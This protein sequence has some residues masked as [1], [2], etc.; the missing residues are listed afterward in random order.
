LKNIT[1]GNQSIIKF[2][3]HA[4]TKQIDAELSVKDLWAALYEGCKKEV[5]DWL[6]KN[7]SFRV[8]RPPT[9]GVEECFN[10]ILAAGQE[11]EQELENEALIQGKLEIKKKVNALRKG[12]DDET[13]SYPIPNV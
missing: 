11:V 2:V 6:V 1:Q 4:R 5:R 10:E 13:V 9:G 12:K 7:T 8:R 3:N